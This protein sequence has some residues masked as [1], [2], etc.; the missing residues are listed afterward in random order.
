MRKELRMNFGEESEFIEHKLSTAE[1]SEALQAMSGMLNK[2]GRGTIYFG[3]ADN[4]EAIGFP[5][6]KDTEN[7]IQQR[8]AQKIDPAPT[9]STVL[10]RIGDGTKGIIEVQFSGNRPPYQYNGRFYMRN[11][12]ADDPMDASELEQY[13]LARRKNYTSWEN[14]EGDQALSDISEHLVEEVYRASKEIQ[15]EYPTYPG[16]EKTL[17][18]F[19]LLCKSAQ[20]N[21]AAVALFGRR[22]I[23]LKTAT[24][25]SFDRSEASDMN[26]VK[27]NIIELISLA[28]D[29]VL[30]HI[31]SVYVNVGTL[32]RETVPEIPKEALR[33]IIVNAFAHADYSSFTSHQVFVYKDRVSIYNP[34]YFPI[35]LKPEDYEAGGVDP[36]ERNPKIYDILHCLGFVETYATGLRKTFAVCQKSKTTISYEQSTQGGFRF[37]FF[38]KGDAIFP[39]LPP[40]ASDEQKLLSILSRDSFLSLEELAARIGKGKVTTHSKI[41]NLIAEGKIKRIGSDKTGHWVVIR[42]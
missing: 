38:R 30:T 6:R 4:G 3:V 39:P 42:K 18:F 11:S 7:D 32:T 9:V 10:T 21:N 8:I 12:R 13:I 2:H 5:C 20:P 19:G 26:V 28:M 17:R 24:Y 31:D 29:Y 25:R 16:V 36:V 23:T 40:D 35:G 27:G 1:L 14:A 22:S 15:R 34:G 37:E 33:E 41:S